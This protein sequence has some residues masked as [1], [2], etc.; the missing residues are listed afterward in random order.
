MP[1]I[2]LK[3]AH[4]LPPDEVKKRI[5]N[6][7]ADLAQRYGLKWRWHDEKTLR[8]E[9]S[10]VKGELTRSDGE[11]GVRVDLPF[12]LRALKGKIVERINQKMDEQLV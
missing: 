6:V 4:R 12:L 7:A 11:V 10:G 9:G 3:R 5:E 2:D 1:D 8:F